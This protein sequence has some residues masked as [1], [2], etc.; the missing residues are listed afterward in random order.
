MVKKHST[1]CSNK[2]NTGVAKKYNS[3]SGGG[4]ERCCK[5]SVLSQSEAQGLTHS[6][7]DLGIG[8]DGRANLA[9]HQ[10]LVL[11]HASQQQHRQLVEVKAHLRTHGALLWGHVV[12]PWGMGGLKPHPR[13]PVRLGCGSGWDGGGLCRMEVVVEERS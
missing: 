4:E 8:E 13:I 7:L 9:S 12:Q 3:I 11:V 5:V 6:G 1:R 10:V 2:V